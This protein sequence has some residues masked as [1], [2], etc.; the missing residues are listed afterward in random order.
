MLKLVDKPDLGSGAQAYGFESLRPHCE[1]ARPLT[2]GL[3]RAW[4]KG[5]RRPTLPHPQTPS[6]GEGAPPHKRRCGPAGPVAS[7]RRDS[8]RS[9]YVCVWGLF[10][11]RKAVWKA[12]VCTGG[13][14]CSR[15]KPRHLHQD[16]GTYSFR[17]TGNLPTGCFSA[18]NVP[19]L[20]TITAKTGYFDSI[21]PIF[22]T[23]PAPR[24]IP[25]YLNR[26]TYFMTHYQTRSY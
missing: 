25:I 3:S 11:T 26:H 15:E 14:W 22:G 21:V 16:V 6:L 4:A 5:L 7:L 19:V 24:P 18:V 8:P 2:A 1:I 17:E 23:I 20:G 12:S 10:C 13:L 9:I